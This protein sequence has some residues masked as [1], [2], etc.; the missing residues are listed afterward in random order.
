MWGT[1]ILW[2]GSLVMVALIAWWV[3][4]QQRDVDGYFTR[5]Y[6]EPPVF[7]WHGPL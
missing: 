4:R 7:Q 6:H 3:H 5:D 2:V 1:L